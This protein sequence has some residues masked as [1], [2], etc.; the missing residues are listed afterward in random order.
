MNFHG[1][2]GNENKKNLALRLAKAI[3]A[4]DVVQ[5]LKEFGYW[6]NNALW[7]YYGSNKPNEKPNNLSHFSNQQSSADSAL[8]EKL[9][10]SID[11]VL[12]RACLE[13]NI[14]PTNVRAP[15]SVE[16]AQNK[17]FNIKNGKLSTISTSER[18]ALAKKI[19]LVA[20]G[21]KSIPTLSIIDQ[22][23]GQ[24][25]MDL[26]NTLLSLSQSNKI[27]VKFVQG[28]F[29]MG[30][31]GA[32]RFCGTEKERNHLQFVL[33]KRM[34]LSPQLQ[35]TSDDAN[36]WGFT[37]VRR[38]DSEEGERNSCYT[39]LAPEQN[40]EV[41]S[42]TSDE[43]NL[44]PTLD[45]ECL[46]SI[47]SGTYIR[48][49]EYK[50][51][52]NL[53]TTI[54]FNLYYRLSLLLPDIALPI[55]MYELRKYKGNTNAKN[56]A[57]LSVRLAEGGEN[58]EDKF[59]KPNTS[60][61]PIDGDSLHCQ[62]YVFRPRKKNN[63]ARE[64][65]VVFSVNGQF[66]GHLPKTF[67]GR[68]KVGLNYL[69]NDVLVIVDCSKLSPSSQE[70]LFMGSRDRL[71][72]GDLLQKITDSLINMLKGDPD[73]KEL[74][75]KRRQAALLGADPESHEIGTKLT[76]EF[77]R[78]RP[79]LVECLRQG[80][81]I[82]NP[83]IMR[84]VA[85]DKELAVEFKEYP[86]F[87]KLRKEFPSN[88]PKLCPQNNEY[89]RVQFETDV[90]SDYF[91]R[92]EGMG[93]YSVKVD[94]LELQTCSFNLYNGLANLN[95]PTVDIGNDIGDKTLIKT[96]ID[97]DNCVRPFESSFCVQIAP[98]QQRNTMN[99]GERAKPPGDEPGDDREKP[100]G[101]DLPKQV[102]LYENDWNKDEYKNLE[103]DGNSAL[104]IMK[105]GNG[106]LYDF[107]LNMDNK[108]L[109]SHLRKIK[110]IP[111]IEKSKSDYVNALTVIGLSIIQANSV[112]EDNPNKE[113]N[114]KT[115]SVEDQVSDFT[116][117]I[118]QI[119]MELIYA[120]LR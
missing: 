1:T 113:E 28:K 27:K 3:K 53:R 68:K 93:R 57:G 84:K 15:N 112:T 26:P 5:I 119:L 70:D 64:E 20:A 72:K 6:D 54:M 41:L 30:G 81:S 21:S 74:N 69:Q 71:N 100:L 12:M 19:A 118:S 115:I 99:K 32:V 108:H 58:L 44:L 75:Q 117:A 106:D 37:V 116:S 89:F 34:P 104:K 2:A 60:R 63:Y 109:H 14:E 52:N 101:L 35:S 49:Y 94:G 36:Q 43:L 9:V 107:Y 17:F 51:D 29:G 40:G 25:P 56:L 87:F 13:K 59:K 61:I 114:D 77:L 111:E 16:D 78:E 8:V 92:G 120:F 65:G 90:E 7:R 55:R 95:I 79:E 88:K 48:L 45:G 31:S 85:D 62:T 18:T 105:A 47:K 22:G 11:A 50:L 82:D 96:T 4:D 73:L 103:F 110:E 98:E 39:Y 46:E 66:H 86:S 76:E 83:H 80:T 23:E 102:R 91:E 10:N 42:F 33:S 97:D 38:Q 24:T 67:F